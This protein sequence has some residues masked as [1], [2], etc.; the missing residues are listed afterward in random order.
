MTVAKSAAVACPVLAVLSLTGCIPIPTL[1]DFI[2]R[3]SCTILETPADRG[4]AFEELQIP[5]PDGE[6]VSAWYVGSEASKALVVVIPGSDTNKGRYV[7]A[8]PLLVPNGYDVLLMDYQGFGATP[9]EPSLEA[10]VR[11]AR[12]VATYAF[13][14]HSR[15]VL[16]GAS[17]GTP[18]VAR[19]AA[20]GDYAACVFE[21]TL[22]LCEEP[23]LWLENE[24]LDLLPVWRLAD[25]YVEPQAPDA[26]DILASIV[27]VEEP[28]LFMHSQED[29]TTP[30]AGG[31]KVFQAAPEAKEFWTMRGEH[32]KMI[33][34][35]PEAYEAKLIGWLD[36]VLNTSD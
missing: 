12:A 35:D 3:P 29:E 1:D 20:E 22:I 23:R 31:R 25:L 15:V 16:F 13:E 6:T 26:F 28:K 19:I 2:L 30:I 18:L 4:F 11:D 32:G 5:V 34:L 27:A 33:D 10:C 36:S 14:R 8:L 9:G 7:R 21:G 24:G 17:L